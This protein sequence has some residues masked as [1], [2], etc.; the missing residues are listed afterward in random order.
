[1]ERSVPCRLPL[2]YLTN[3][4]VTSG[5]RSAWHKNSFSSKKTKHSKLSLCRPR[6]TEVA[7]IFKHEDGNVVSPTH[8]PPLPTGKIRGTHFCQRLHLPQGHSAAE[9]IR[10]MKNASGPI[11]NQTRDLPACSAVPQRTAQPRLSSAIH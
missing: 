2:F 7:R 11:G 6:K 3:T 5:R 4:F 8:R 1:M 9:W 10:S